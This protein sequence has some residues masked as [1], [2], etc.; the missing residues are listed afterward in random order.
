MVS[1]GAS[2]LPFGAPEGTR[3]IYKSPSHYRPGSVPCI[4]WPYGRLTA[5][6]FQYW[7]I[8]KEINI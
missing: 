3:V 7:D 5:T 2:R 6:F 8:N 1:T 4:Y